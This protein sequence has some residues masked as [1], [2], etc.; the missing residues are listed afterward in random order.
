M[1][2][3]SERTKTRIR[4]GVL[5][6]ICIA[7]AL[8][9]ATTIAGTFQDS[10][11]FATLSQ[12]TSAGFTG[13][14]NQS[15]IQNYGFSNTNNASGVAG[16][17][18]GSFRMEASRTYYADT[19]LNGTLTNADNLS[20]GG[21]FKMTNSASSASQLFIAHFDPT[22]ATNQN[23][24]GLRIV[25]N[26][27]N[28]ANFRFQAFLSY[29]NGGT[30]SGAIVVVPNTV[31]SFS[32]VFDPDPDNNPITTPGLLTASFTD[33][34]TTYTSS[35]S[36]TAALPA[37]FSAWGLRTDVL[38]GFESANPLTL[39]IDDVNY[40]SIPEPATAG[41]IVLAGW[42]LSSRLFRGFGYRR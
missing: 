39:F 36:T 10:Q 1:H 3:D 25:D 18:G 24:L 42:S 19:T 35:T 33:G 5:T 30:D 22:P 21:A 8:G 13:L 34:V 4:A 23:I 28:A 16:E 20:A 37:S 41:L 15:S 31:T 2:R 29:S 11:D 6:L 7:M 27:S 14:N 9:A 38:G 12:A 17:A 40:T 32:Y 26:N